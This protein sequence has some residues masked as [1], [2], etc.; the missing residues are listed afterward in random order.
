MFMIIL[1]VT[2]SKHSNFLWLVD[3][4]CIQMDFVSSNTK[5]FCCTC[6]RGILYLY[7]QKNTVYNQ[8]R[9]IKYDVKEGP[10]ILLLLF[11]SCQLCTLKC[12]VNYMEQQ[13]CAKCGRAWFWQE[14][15][16]YTW[17]KH[18]GHDKHSDPC[19]FKMSQQV[20]TFWH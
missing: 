18:C 2:I 4:K 15:S 17:F 11:L 6:S 20:K 7:F 14:N 8:A 12:W 1:S 13:F 5:S 10:F 9:L 19:I 16:I 3:H